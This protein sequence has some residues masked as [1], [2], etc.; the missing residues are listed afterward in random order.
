MCSGQFCDCESRGGGFSGQL[1]A[2]TTDGEWGLKE[3][4]EFVQ[5][6][7]G[8]SLLPKAPMTE[9]PLL[10]APLVTQLLA[11]GDRDFRKGYLARD[12]AHKVP[13]V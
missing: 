8:P 7:P 9:C 6:A 5:G 12:M 4:K 11:V 13:L 2:P 10:M 1:W 3:N